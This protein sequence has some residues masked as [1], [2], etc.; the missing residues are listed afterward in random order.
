[1]RVGISQLDA[2]R[3]DLNDSSVWVVQRWFSKEDL[4][5]SLVASTYLPCFTGP[6]SFV[7]YRDQ[8]A[9]DG[10]YAVGWKDVW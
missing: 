1:M 5:D 9:I 10:G 2:S 8:P 7:V 4:V 6:T 3:Q